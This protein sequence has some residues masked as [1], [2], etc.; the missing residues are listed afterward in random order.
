MA[1]TRCHLRR[2]TVAIQA[3]AEA[4]DPPEAQRLAYRVLVE[5]RLHAGVGLVEHEPDPGARGMVLFEP[6]APL[7]AISNLERQEFG[8][9][10]WCRVR[11][12]FPTISPTY[13]RTQ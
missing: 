3:F 11:C 10:C 5:H 1:A 2:V 13:P 12:N 8:R 4:V 9:H 6:R 7:S